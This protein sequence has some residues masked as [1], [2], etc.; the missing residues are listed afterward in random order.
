MTPEEI[1]QLI[2]QKVEEGDPEVLA[3]ISLVM[4]NRLLQKKEDLKE[5]ETILLSEV[6]K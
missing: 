6:Q 5:I 1:I 2:I 4:K 3:R